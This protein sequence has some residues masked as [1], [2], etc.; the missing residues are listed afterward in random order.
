[1]T[2]SHGNAFPRDW[3]STGHRWIPLIGPVMRSFDVFFH[4]SHN[5]RTLYSYFEETTYDQLYSYF[6]ETTVWPIYST[7]LTDVLVILDNSGVVD[8]KR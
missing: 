4:F 6:E 5:S 3:R 7:Y 1:M 2:S 8:T